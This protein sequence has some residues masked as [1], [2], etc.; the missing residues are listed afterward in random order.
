MYSYKFFQDSI[1]LAFIFNSFIYFELFLHMVWDRVLISFL[2]RY[3]VSTQFL[4][5][6]T[7]SLLNYLGTLVGNPLP[8]EI[9]V[10]LWTLNFITL[11]FMAI[12]ITVSH[13]FSHCNFIVSFEVCKYKFSNFVHLFQDYFKIVLASLSP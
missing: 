12:L 11:S 5:K 3:L 4:E 9:C 10:Y 1:M 8:I 6:T 2:Y 7:I 13:Y